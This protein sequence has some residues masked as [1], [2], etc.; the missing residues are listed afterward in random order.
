LTLAGEFGHERKVASL[1]ARQ[2]SAVAGMTMSQTADSLAGLAALFVRMDSTDESAALTAKNEAARLLAAA[3]MSFSAIAEQLEQRRLLI[4][5][6]L[7]AAIKRMDLPGEGDAAFYGTRKLLGRAKLSF[8]HIA[9]ALAAASVSAAERDALAQE[10]AALREA[11]ERQ[12]GIIAGLKPMT[13]LSLGPLQRIWRPILVVAAVVLTIGL[14]AWGGARALVDFGGDIAD[15]LG[16]GRAPAV[17]DE[18]AQ[19]PSQPPVDQP[20]QPSMPPQQNAHRGEEKTTAPSP[21]IEHPR[22]GQTPAQQASRTQRPPRRES[23]TEEAEDEPLLRTR[24]CWGG[25]GACNWGGAR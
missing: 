12:Q 14:G 3:R 18:P 1:L 6:D 8:E 25:V 19:P 15:A 9:R 21:A 2:T 16:P 24:R 20:I 22:R 23:V 17:V 11:Y 4:P 7:V 5:P 10:L 13:G